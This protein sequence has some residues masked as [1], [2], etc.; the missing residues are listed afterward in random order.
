LL[1]GTSWLRRCQK[2]LLLGCPGLGE[3]YAMT[4]P[5]SDSPLPPLQ[6][7]IVAQTAHARAG[8]CAGVSKE[9]RRRFQTPVTPHAARR[10]GTPVAAAFQRTL[11]RLP[12]SA[13]S[14]LGESTRYVMHR[15]RSSG[16]T[17]FT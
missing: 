17:K 7:R 14:A 8:S 15:A 11:T 3:A 16:E 10:G 9:H 6:G 4:N 12:A 5:L 13:T 1:H 2:A